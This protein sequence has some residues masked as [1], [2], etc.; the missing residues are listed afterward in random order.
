[1]DCR[2]STDGR[3]MLQA[4][5]PREAALFDPAAGLHVR[6][7]LGGEAFPPILLYKVFT[8]RTVTDV[9]SFGPRDYAQESHVQV[10]QDD[11]KAS[12]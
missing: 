2:E 11:G 7:R 6:F 9:G 3:T 4:I 12:R 1:M 10:Q 8:H 5:N